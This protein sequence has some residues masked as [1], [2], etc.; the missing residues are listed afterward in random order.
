MTDT[1]VTGMATSLCSTKLSMWLMPGTMIHSKTMEIVTPPITS[2]GVCWVEERERERGGGG[3]N[4]M[5]VY[6]HVYVCTSTV[7]TR[8]EWTPRYILHKQT[9]MHQV[10]AISRP[11]QSGNCTQ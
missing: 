8:S 9:E 1:M 3:G 10:S 5:Y 7:H 11:S 4:N 6:K 2:C